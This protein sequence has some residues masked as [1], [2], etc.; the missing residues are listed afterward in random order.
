MSTLREFSCGASVSPEHGTSAEK[1][2]KSADEALYRAKKSGQ[3]C[4]KVRPPGC[5]GRPSLTQNQLGTEVVATSTLD[6]SKS[7]RFRQVPGL[8][9][10]FFRLP[11]EQVEIF[12]AIVAR[13][14]I[15]GARFR[16]T[17]RRIASK[18]YGRINSH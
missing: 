2:L 6:M 14:R 11:I 13:R 4:V 7:E 3:N 10:C 8:L 15:S 12:E 5:A 18:S 17:S 1:L 9:K 16:S